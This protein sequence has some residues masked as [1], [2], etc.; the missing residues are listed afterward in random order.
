MKLTREIGEPLIKAFESCLKPVKGRPGYFTTY[1]CPAG[2]LTIGWGTTRSDVKNLTPGTVW[3]QKQCDDAF[4]EGMPKYE[5]QVIKCLQGAKVTQH[6]FDALVSWAYNT[7]GP[8]SASLWR[9]VRSGDVERA[10]ASLMQWTKGG[11][12]VLPGL[13]RR[14]KAECALYRG[15]PAEALRIAGTKPAPVKTGVVAGIGTS[16]AVAAPAAAEAAGAPGWLGWA[17]AVV[18]VLGV[19]AAVVAYAIRRNKT[20]PTG[21]ANTPPPGQISPLD[22]DADD[23]G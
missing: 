5:R 4:M 1:Y 2:V 10:C 14:R 3:S 22:M 17:V 16:I 7:G 18:L 8:A 11:G 6:Q 19:V 9:H 15:N 13:V 21:M 23:E 12:R 20:E